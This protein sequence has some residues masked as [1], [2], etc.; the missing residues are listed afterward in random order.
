MFSY[1]KFI[2]IFNPKMLKQPQFKSIKI[3]SLNFLHSI[4]KK[5]H[6]DLLRAFQK[7]STM[8]ILNK[9]LTTQHQ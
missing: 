4:Q 8:N 5:K 1:E 6:P 3:K 9:F 7:L 2:E